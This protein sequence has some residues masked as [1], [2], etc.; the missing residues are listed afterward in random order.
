M[1]REAGGLVAPRRRAHQVDLD[2]IASGLRQRAAEPVALT[3]SDEQRLART[4]RQ[5]VEIGLR[6]VG[7]E[8]HLHALPAA[9]VDEEAR[10]FI[11]ADAA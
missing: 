4:G 11:A 10:R 2:D 7:A 5:H 9:R 6:I 8:R 3:R 1:E